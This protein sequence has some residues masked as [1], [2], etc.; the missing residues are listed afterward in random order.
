[1]VQIDFPKAY[2]SGVYI[3][4]EQGDEVFCSIVN[5]FGVSALTLKYDRE[6]NRVRISNIIKQMDRFFIRKVLKADFKRIIP[7]MCGFDEP[8]DYKYI[9]PRIEITYTFTALGQAPD[10]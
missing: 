6:K 2:L 9:N 3:L 10:A 5:E 4:R 8:K 1:M 7:E